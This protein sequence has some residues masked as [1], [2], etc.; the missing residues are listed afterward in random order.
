M[1]DDPAAATFRVQLNI[2]GNPFWEVDDVNPS[3][4]DH[5]REALDQFDWHYAMSDDHSVYQRGRARH[6]ELLRAGEAL[7]TK[8]M[9]L[10]RIAEL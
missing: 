1:A 8:E 10:N 6:D 7:G 9:F 2:S 5:Y 4:V 3:T